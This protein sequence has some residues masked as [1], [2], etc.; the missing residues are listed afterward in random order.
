MK[1]VY[2]EYS[3]AA[4]PPVRSVGNQLSVLMETI[5]GRMRRSRQHRPEGLCQR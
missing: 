2:D 1:K 5:H 3:G 4:K